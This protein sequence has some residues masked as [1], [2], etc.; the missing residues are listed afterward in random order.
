MISNLTLFFLLLFLITGCSTKGN[1]AY[2]KRVPS[3]TSVKKTTITKSRSQNYITTSL[4]REYEK[5]KN[6]PYRLGGEDLNGIDCSSF[7]Q[8]IYK[9]AFNINLP[10]TTREQV[11]KGYKVNRSNSKE[12]DLI[13]FKTGYNIRHT[14]II[15]EEGKFIH[16]SQKHGVTISDIYNPYWRNR[17]WQTR[18]VL[19]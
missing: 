12:G 13:F 19:P 17:Y 2:T 6:T 11:K 10:R 18:R 7:I 3:T 1:P 8:T 9:N 4:Y 16:A 5:Y 15:I 14:G